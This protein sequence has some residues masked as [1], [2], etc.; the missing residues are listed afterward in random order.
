MTI[1]IITATYNSAAT[2]ADTLQSVLEQTYQDFEV[3]VVDG[4]SSDK[5]LEIVRSFKPAFQGKLRIVS[6]PDQ[7]LYD[8]MNKGLLMATGQVVGILNSDDFFSTPHSLEYIAQAFENP[9]VDACYGNLYF[10]QPHALKVPVRHYTAGHFRRWMMR[11]GYAPPHPTFYCR[12]EIYVQRLTTI[13]IPHDLVT[14]RMGGVS[15]AGWK[16]YLQGLK[17]RL[18]ALKK[19]RVYSNFFFLLLPYCYK[20]CQM[21]KSRFV[22]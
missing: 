11:L 6:E 2:I 20:A 17:D 8:A 13:H 1:T 5:T 16:S 18:R 21:L 14:M 10:V 9:S 3:I 22:R 15:T 12:K 4:V 19:N 7:G